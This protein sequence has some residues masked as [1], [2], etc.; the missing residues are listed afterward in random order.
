MKY[1]KILFIGILT[2]SLCGAAILFYAYKIEPNQVTISQY[3]LNRNDIPQDSLIVVQL[4]DIEISK[5]FTPEQFEAVVNKVNSLDA[6]II[7]FTGDLFSNYG[8]YHPETRMIELLDS[9]QAHYSK[10][11]ILGNNDH[12][13]GAIRHYDRIMSESGFTVLKNSSKL[14]SLKNGKSVFIAGLDDDLLGNPDIEITLNELN[15][16][17]D[18]NILLTH[19]PYLAERAISYPINLILSGHTHGGQIDFPFIDTSLLLT[20]LENKYIRGFYQFENNIGTQLY[21]N[22]GLG[23]SRLPFRFL[24]KPEISV[25]NIYL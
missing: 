2:L 18:Y 3:D 17:S 16:Q 10:F 5:N 4:S 20:P 25:F 19:E 9:L 23:T 11:A 7:V 22:S 1:I 15:S 24:V 13:G 21:V 6:D 8:K 14:I 12:G